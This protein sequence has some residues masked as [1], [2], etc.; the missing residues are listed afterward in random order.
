M[1]AGDQPPV[2]SPEDFEAELTP[3]QLRPIQFIVAAVA[4]ANALMLALPFVLKAAGMFPDKPGFTNATA[5]LTPLT[6]GTM[7]LWVGL[8]YLAQWVFAWQLRP[9]RVAEA[10]GRAGGA[11]FGGP[12]SDTPAGRCLSHIRRAVFLRV[13]CYDGAA[14]LGV[15]TCMIAGAMGQLPINSLY[16]INLAPA[17]FVLIYAL[18][19][20][21]TP[22]RLRN[23]FLSRVAGAGT[24][25]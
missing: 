13:V 21:P 4:Q 10:V 3:R 8:H 20:F 6:I 7:A 11:R 1:N 5:L 2:V 18:V 14:A 24:T 22:V 19:T 15:G 16:W 25:P 23:V 12:A 17:A 9:E